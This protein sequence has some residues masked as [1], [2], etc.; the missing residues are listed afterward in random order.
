MHVRKHQHWSQVTKT[1]A[2]CWTPGQGE[3]DRPTREV[4]DNVFGQVDR[5][6]ENVEHTLSHAGASWKDVYAIRLYH[7]ADL[8]EDG[9]KHFVECMRKWMLDHG[10]ILSGI[11]IASLAFGMKVAV[12]VEA[13]VPTKAASQGESP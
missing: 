9:V 3:W 10:P 8:P 6:F 5:A 2:C 12:Q 11:G 7:T 13:H 4:P 1:L